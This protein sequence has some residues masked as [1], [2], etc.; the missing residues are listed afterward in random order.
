M[1]KK[2]DFS[3]MSKLERQALA[4]RILIEHPRFTKL[5]EKIKH[6]HQYSKIAAE[7]ECM[8]ISGYSGTGKTT[9]YKYYERQYPRTINN[10]HTNIP[11]GACIEQ[12][13]R[14]RLFQCPR[15]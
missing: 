10:S 11:V 5:L 14:N 9:L 12:P 15:V 3:K 13:R 1:S 6:C 2:R 8:F 7:P 4:E